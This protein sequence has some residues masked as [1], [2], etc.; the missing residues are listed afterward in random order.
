MIGMFVGDENRVDALQV[1]AD[2]QQPFRQLLHA[3]ACVDQDA[4]VFSSQK[5]GI[6]GTA[7]RQHTELNDTRLPNLLS[8]DIPEYT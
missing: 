8:S 3:E 2:G 4:R 6:S 1:L 5:G 7:A